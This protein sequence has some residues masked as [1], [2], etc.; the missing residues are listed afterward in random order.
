MNA[1]RINL[2][3]TKKDKTGDISLIINCDNKSQAFNF[4]YEFFEL[5]E[6]NTVY[7]TKETGLSTI[8]RWMPNA[9][10]MKKYAGKYKVFHSSIKRIE[11]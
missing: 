10:E 11:E 1:Y 4:A 9:E 8:H 5:G 3:G 2:K 6:T 7:G